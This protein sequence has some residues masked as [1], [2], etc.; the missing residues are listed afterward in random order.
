V[1]ANHHLVDVFIGQGDAAATGSKVVH[2]F[3]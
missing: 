2:H 1:Q 3:L